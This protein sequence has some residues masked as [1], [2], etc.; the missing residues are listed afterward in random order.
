MQ[1]A[2]PCKGRLGEVIVDGETV[3]VRA[4]ANG[5][6]LIE[7]AD[8]QVENRVGVLGRHVAERTLRAV[9]VRVHTE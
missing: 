1:V 3:L 8:I 9:L 4:G 5:W 2:D 7:L 6:E